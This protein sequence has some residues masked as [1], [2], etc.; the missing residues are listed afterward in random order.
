MSA[1]GHF[2]T[3]LYGKV[4]ILK[5]A[6]DAHNTNVTGNIHG[7]VSAASVNMILRRDSSG[8]ADIVAPAADDNT[9][10][11]PTTAWVQTE[12]TGASGVTSVETGVGLTGGP[13]TGSGTIDLDNTS[14]AAGSYTLASITVDA[15]GR[16]TSASSGAAVVTNVTGTSPMVSS[17]GTT[18]AISIPN[19]TGS[20]R[21]SMSSSD[22]SKLDN[23]DSNATDGPID[24]VFGRTGAVVAVSGDYDIQDI[25]DV[26]ISDSAASGSPANGAIWFEY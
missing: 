1:L 22:K 7:A 24:T 8:R 5:T 23:I 10:K 17:G 9:T 21:G 12:I 16:L 18:P 6:D 20:V 11:I 2:V 25:G 14:V 26:T 13:I 15:Q 19:A 4:T 3:G